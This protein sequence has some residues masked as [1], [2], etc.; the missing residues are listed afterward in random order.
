MLKKSGRTIDI[1]RQLV[2][3]IFYGALKDLYYEDKP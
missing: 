2:Y 3:N 1:F